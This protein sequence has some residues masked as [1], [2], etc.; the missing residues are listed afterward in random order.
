MLVIC[1]KSL[2]IVGGEV[3]HAEI[4]VIFIGGIRRLGRFVDPIQD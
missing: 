1:I 2:C 4:N 3:Q